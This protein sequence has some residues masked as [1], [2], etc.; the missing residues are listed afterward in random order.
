MQDVILLMRASSQ[1]YEPSDIVATVSVV[2]IGIRLG[3][4]GPQ[5]PYPVLE[6]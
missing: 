3:P 5:N 1:F 6:F 4:S 2:K